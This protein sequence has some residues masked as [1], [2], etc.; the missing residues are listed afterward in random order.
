[1]TLSTR[2]GCPCSTCSRLT[3]GVCEKCK[4]SSCARAL[5]C[6]YTCNWEAERSHP[7]TRR[8]RSE[9]NPIVIRDFKKEA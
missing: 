6:G 3:Q 8:Y 2:G 1:M 9:D 7:V 5:W 4:S